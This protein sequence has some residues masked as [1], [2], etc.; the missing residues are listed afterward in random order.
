MTP[1]EILRK[2]LS[3]EI[4]TP[5]LVSNHF[6]QLQMSGSIEGYAAAASLQ[7]AAFDGMPVGLKSAK[8]VHHTLF[9]QVPVTG[10]SSHA[11]SS[12]QAP[13]SATDTPDK[14]PGSL[15]VWALLFTYIAHTLCNLAVLQFDVCSDLL[16]V[17]GPSCVDLPVCVSICPDMF[18]LSH[19]LTKSPYPP[20]PHTPPDPP[21]A[22]CPAV[23]S[24]PVHMYDCK[25]LVAK[26]L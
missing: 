4:T 3:T 13:D 20:P 25:G 1:Y 8:L 21:C 9:G 15:Q 2:Y 11:A 17:S 6:Q 7:A 23:C 26:L 22:F 19:R 16:Y 18:H 12:G 14:L 10:S 5:V 24:Q